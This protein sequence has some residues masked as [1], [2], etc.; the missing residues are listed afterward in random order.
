MLYL[1]YSL[2]GKPPA[3]ERRQSDLRLDVPSQS[4]R[5]TEPLRTESSKH[6]IFVLYETILVL[7]QHPALVLF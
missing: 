7:Y 3:P 5:K 1:P 4:D 6:E 2:Q